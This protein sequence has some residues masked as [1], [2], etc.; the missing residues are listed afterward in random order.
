[1]LPRPG[2]GSGVENLPS[3]CK[4]TGYIRN[5]Q[6]QKNIIKTQWRAKGSESSRVRALTVSGWEMLAFLSSCCLFQYIVQRHKDSYRKRDALLNKNQK[7]LE[8]CH[9]HLWPYLGLKGRRQ[10]LCDLLWVL[11]IYLLS[12]SCNK[13]FFFSILS[14]SLNE[15]KAD[16]ELSVFTT[17]CHLAQKLS[18]PSHSQSA[19]KGNIKSGVRKAS[20]CWQTQV[21][22]LSPS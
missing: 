8:V 18:T 11:F 20:S 2:D 4:D 6:N 17:A 1:M 21:T 5:T 10:G 22:F 13:D 19:S 14:P 7:S 9:L 12:S 16:Q 15:A 3:V